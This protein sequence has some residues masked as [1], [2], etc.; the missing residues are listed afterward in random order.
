MGRE[1]KDMQ[2][3]DTRSRSKKANNDGD[4]HGEDGGNDGGIY[5][6]HDHDGDFD[7]E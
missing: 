5:D 7:I 4:K 6:Y 1:S 3:A 2:K